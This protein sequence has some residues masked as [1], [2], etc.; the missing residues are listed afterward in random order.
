MAT[1]PGDHRRTVTNREL[2]I[3]AAFA[4]FGAALA[5]LEAFGTPL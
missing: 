2:I 4:L 1:M 5:F 3:L